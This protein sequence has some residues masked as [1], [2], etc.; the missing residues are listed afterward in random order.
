MT[1]RPLYNPHLHTSQIFW[2][3]VEALT[4]P[5]ELNP[6]LA[7]TP[8][9][10]TEMRIPAFTPRPEEVE[11]VSRLIRDLTG[12]GE[13]GPVVLLNANCSDLLPLRLWDRD[14]YV[15]LARLLLQKYPRIHIAF[16]GA[17]N[18]AP[19]VEKLLARI[20]N[21]RAVCLAGR[22]TLRQLLVAYSLSELLVTNDSGPAHFA[23]LTPIDVITLFGPE[24]PKLFCSTSPRAHV[25]WSGIFCS[26]CV[27]AYNNRF[28][29]CRDNLCM[30]MIGV[31]DVF[32]KSCEIL[33]RRLSG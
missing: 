3:M 19:E 23:T 16:T 17:P 31:A 24:T 13:V 30:K 25:M 10:L 21:P 15:K 7:I 28:S 11:E 26:P 6:A 1:H 32:A 8:P 33:D 27:S 9:P 22:T 29:T 18:E 20:D 12:A 14:N 4:H 2:S 5:P